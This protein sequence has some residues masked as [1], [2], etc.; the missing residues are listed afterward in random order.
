VVVTLKTISFK[1]DDEMYKQLK[2]LARK[3][4]ETVSEVVRKAVIR[5]LKGKHVVVLR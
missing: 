3:E 1:L 4:H 5:L 2:D